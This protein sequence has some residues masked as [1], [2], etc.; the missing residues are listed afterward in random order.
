MFSASQTLSGNA[1]LNWLSAFGIIMHWL[2][3]DGGDVKIGAESIAAQ[4]AVADVPFSRRD[5]T[6]KRHILNKL[7]KH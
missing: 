6:N 5:M 1:K 3:R 7:K 2:A 4:A